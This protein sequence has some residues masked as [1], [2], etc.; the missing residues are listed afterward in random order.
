MKKNTPHDLSPIKEE[1]RELL[2]ETLF[3]DFKMNRN[4]LEQYSQVI[5][6]D[7]PTL[8]LIQ[9]VLNLKAIYLFDPEYEEVLGIEVIKILKYQSKRIN[10][11]VSEIKIVCLREAREFILM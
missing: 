7:R 3:D 1:T 5:Q 6:Y 10:A 9:T 2:H 8:T 11:S 4:I